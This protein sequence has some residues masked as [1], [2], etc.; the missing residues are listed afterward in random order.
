MASKIANYLT[1]QER[2]AAMRAGMVLACAE[3][4]TPLT[5]VAAPGI[6]P[7]G[8]MKAIIAV[9]VLTGI[10]IGIAAHVV[11]QRI[12]KERGKEKELQTQTGYYRNAAQQLSRSLA[13]GSQVS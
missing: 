9:S 6:S 5:K 3:T 13:A 1:P 7:G 11:G 8:T 12:T 2:A 10:P 4:N